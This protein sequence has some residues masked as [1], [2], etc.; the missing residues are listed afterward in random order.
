MTLVREYAINT[1]KKKAGKAVDRP[2][3]LDNVHLTV[4]AG[5]ESV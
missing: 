1:R 4:T 2:L 5:R 3:E